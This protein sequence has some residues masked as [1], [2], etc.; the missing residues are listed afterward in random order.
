MRP[1]EPVIGFL[2]QL[3]RSPPEASTS[4]ELRDRTCLQ[5]V[6]INPSISFFNSLRSALVELNQSDMRRP[7]EIFS[8]VGALL[9]HS[10]CVEASLYPSE[11]DVSGSLVVEQL[12]KLATFSDHPNPAVTRIVFTPNDMKARA[13]APSSCCTPGAA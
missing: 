11:L 12:L 3:A 8:Y 13:Q 6:S 5:H 1:A 2:V 9:L 7:V 10:L 4:P